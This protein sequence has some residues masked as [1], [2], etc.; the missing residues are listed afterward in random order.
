MPEYLAPG[1]YVEEVP[2][3]VK[4]IAGSWSKPRAVD[5]D[6]LG[7]IYVLDSSS[8]SI[9]VIDETG[10]KITRITASLPGVGALRTAEDVAVD[11]A[12]QVYIADSKLQ[13]VYRLN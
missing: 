7:N 13:T 6:W 12:G 5:V 10:A 9:E 2:S 1:V 11:G 8:N 4:A 3:A